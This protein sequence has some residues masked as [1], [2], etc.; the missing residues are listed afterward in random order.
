MSTPTSIH[1]GLSVLTGADA[2]QRLAHPLAATVEA[3]YLHSP[4][5][6]FNGPRR[7]FNV[8]NDA[9]TRIGYR[10]SDR[11]DHPAGHPGIDYLCATGQEVKAMFGGVVSEIGDSSLLSTPPPIEYK[12]VTIRSWTN[13]DPSRG[14]RLGFQ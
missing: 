13:W 14:T 1:H 2:S 3:Y 11:L 4:N 9:L 6:T 8:F 5:Q 10:D 7:V 12:N